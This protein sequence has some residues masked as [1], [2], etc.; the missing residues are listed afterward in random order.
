VDDK[1]DGLAEISKYIREIND[2]F[3]KDGYSGYATV[4]GYESAMNQTSLF[5]YY[6]VCYCNIT[7]GEVSETTYFNHR[8]AMHEMKQLLQGGVCAWI[9]QER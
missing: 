8:E 9:K 7:T 2:A 6:I 4:D 1:K 3:Y 5:D